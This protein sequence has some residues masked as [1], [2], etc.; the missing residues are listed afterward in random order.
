MEAADSCPSFHKLHWEILEDRNLW[1]NVTDAPSSIFIRRNFKGNETISPFP[2][3]RK[4]NVLMVV[5]RLRE[6]GAPEQEEQGP[7]KESENVFK[8]PSLGLGI[9]PRLMSLPII[10][11]RERLW[12]EHGLVL[13]IEIARPG[14]WKAVGDHLKMRGPGFFD[15]VHFDVHGSV[16]KVDNRSAILWNSSLRT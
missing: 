2:E 6:Y 4:R 5:S 10:L 11:L 1:P 9:S 8:S 3:V 15:F 12:E 13:N 14:T 16:N 7:L